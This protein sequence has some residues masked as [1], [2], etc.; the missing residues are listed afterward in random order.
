MER[1]VSGVQ[2]RSFEHQKSFRNAGSGNKASQMRG[3]ATP[4]IRL[5]RQANLPFSMR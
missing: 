1:A 5:R 3:N 4:A 2:N